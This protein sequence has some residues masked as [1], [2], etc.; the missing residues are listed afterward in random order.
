MVI[1][2]VLTGIILLITLIILKVNPMLAL[3]IVSIITG[4][5]L[6]MPFNKVIASINNG[7]GNTLGGTVMILALGAM[8]G[9]LAEESGAGQKLVIS[10]V[11]LFGKNYIV[12][13][14]LLTGIVAGIPLFYNA[15]FVIL[16][17]LVFAIASTLNYPLLMLGIPMAAALSITHGFLPPHPGPITLATIFHANVGKIL[18]YGLVISIPTAVIAGI[19]FPKLIKANR[20][21]VHPNINFALKETI[22]L[23]SLS[24]SI[25]ILLAPVIFISFGTLGVYITSNGMALNIFSFL[26]E[27][28]IALLLSLAL[29]F[30][31]LN[32]NISH[33]MITGIEGIKAITMI[34]LIIA[35][36]GAFKQ[37][38]LDSNIGMILK[39]Y[40]ASM[41]LSPLFLG[42]LIAAL[43]RITL[44]S[45]TVAALS[46]SGIVAPFIT[47]GVSA[48][49]MVLSVGAG[50]LMCSHVNDTGFWMFKE[51]FGLNL[52]DTFRTWTLMESIISL[53]GLLFI[54]SIQAFI[55]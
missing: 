6:K 26:Q 39:N 52:K 21:S 35:A 20:I 17:P 47:G 18:L 54:F 51:Y 22:D 13:A 4:L 14:V 3:L 7:I 12:W 8:L 40:T 48:E 45:A 25:L 42:W 50:S 36:G 29:T 11:K 10:L 19:I 34:L 27:P 46:A 30:V 43:F 37:I 38:L 5:L 28:T 44:G 2:T 1:I 32:W 23:P 9:K 55:A 16:I 15:G 24:K 49:L 31:L 53:L 33:F 41:H